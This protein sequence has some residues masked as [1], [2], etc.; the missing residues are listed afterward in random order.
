MMTN[1]SHD[2]RTPLTSA[3]GY[4]GMLRNA[5]LTEEEKHRELEIVEKRLQRLEELINAF[6]EFSSVISGEKV[7]ETVPLNLVGVLEEAVGHFFDEFST[8]NREIRLVCSETKLSLVSNRNM[9][10]RIFDNLIGNACRHGQGDLQIS[11]AV[12]DKISVCFENPLCDPNMEIDRVFD[13]FYT[14]DISRTKGHTG[15][16]LAIAKQFTGLLG[17][18]ICAD[19]RDGLF[20]VTVI[21][22]SFE[23]A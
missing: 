18:G 22:R 10:L 9:L 8:Q 1:I 12:A 3:L 23:A 17:G 20:S 5:D 16:G 6:F 15:L 21:L 19:Y 2:L 4:V 11:V 7:P 13:E 14:T